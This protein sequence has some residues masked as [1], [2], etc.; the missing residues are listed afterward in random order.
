[1]WREN[2]TPGE[3]QRWHNDRSKIDTGADTSKVQT[4]LRVHDSLPLD[5]HASF[6]GYTTL[7]LRSEDLR[8]SDGGAEEALPKE[9]LT[10]TKEV[11]LSQSRTLHTH[12]Y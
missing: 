12:S 6:R 4:S 7:R 10:S 8:P 2:G 11:Y 1:M 3:L 5:V 9:W